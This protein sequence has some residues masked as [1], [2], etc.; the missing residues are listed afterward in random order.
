MPSFPSAK[1]QVSEAEWDAR[2][3]LAASYRLVAYHGWDDMLS[4]HISA[5]V[6]DERDSMLLSPY[7]LLFGQVTA[8]SLVKVRISDGQVLNQSPLRMNPAA[9]NIHAGVLRARDEAMSA[10][11]LHTVAGVAVSSL[12]DGLMPL[13]QRA[14]Y[15]GP[16]NTA[17]HGYEGIATEA[18]EQESLAR[19][20][21]D[22]WVMFLRNHG[23]LT[24]G[25][26]VA[27]A[28]VSAFFLERA[29]QM[30]VATLSMGQPVTVLPPE[31]VTLV[32]DQ[33]KHVRHWGRMEWPALLT[34][35]RQ[36]NPGFDI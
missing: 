18:S 34:L 13:N 28:F 26:T 2:V 23:T 32:A 15:F 7:G 27:Q 30:Q 17:Y 5:R 8:S 3:D 9:I 33:A 24:L 14:C 16:H 10:L 11:H 1:D 20:L 36:V 6:P 35:L 29:C 21:G 12:K 25:R 4:T 22:K 19:D 31:L